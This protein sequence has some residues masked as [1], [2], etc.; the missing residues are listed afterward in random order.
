MVVTVGKCILLMVRGVVILF[1]FFPCDVFIVE[2]LQLREQRFGKGS[3]S[4]EDESEEESEEEETEEKEVIPQNSSEAPKETADSAATTDTREQQ[5]LA[6]RARLERMRLE[7]AKAMAEAPTTVFSKATKESKPAP[8]ANNDETEDKPTTGLT[9]KQREQL[10]AEQRKLE[11]QRRH[12]A[13]ETEQAKRELQQVRSSSLSCTR[14]VH[15]MFRN[16]CV[17]VVLMITLIS[18]IVARCSTEA[19]RRSR[20]Q[21]PRTSRRRASCSFSG[22]CG[23]RRFGFLR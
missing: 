18:C 10:E 4:E 20:T 17:I 5:L 22:H 6:M 11:Y 16:V 2:E 21:T 15:K 13:G 23:R 14:K 3:D 12:N 8:I 19:P 7:K 9:R 1:Y